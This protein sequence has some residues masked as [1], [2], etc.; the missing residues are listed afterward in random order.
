MKKLS[1][2]KH[3]ILSISALFL[4][5][6]VAAGITFSWIEGGSSFVIKSDDTNHTLKTGKL[7]D[8]NHYDGLLLDPDTN[9][10]LDLLKFDKN[11]GDAQDLIFTQTYSYDGENFYF[12]ADEN[13]HNPRIATTN[14]KGT[15]FINFSF[16]SKAVKDCYL[17]FDNE[18]PL[19]ITATKGGETIDTSAFRVMIKCGNDK[20]IL[21]TAPSEQTSKIYDNV[22]NEHTLTAEPAST[23]NYIN[24]NDTTALS[25][26][27]KDQEK[28][29]E[30]SVWLDAQ[31]APAELLGG[32]A[33]IEMQIKVAVRKFDITF[34]A[35]T[36]TNTG[37]A[38]VSSFTGGDITV[39]GLKQTAKY[40]NPYEAGTSFTAAA[41]PAAN[42]DFKGWY[43]NDS[44]CDLASRVSEATE[45][46]Y[47]VIDNA[48]YYA[49]FVEK[50]KYDISV[51]ARA[52]NT[53]DATLSNGGGTVY[54]NSSD[55]TT[56]SA[57][58]DSEVT[59]CAAPDS[60][61]RFDGWYT[62]DACT[63]NIGDSYRD[64][65]LQVKV[66]DTTTYYA[67]FVKQFTVTL[68]SVTD[69][70]ISGTGGEGHIDADNTGADISKTVDVGTSVSL[71]GSPNT[72]YEYK[73]IYAT[74]TGGTEITAPVIITVNTDVTYY[75][76]FEEL[77][78]YTITLK[79]VTDGE[80]SGTGGDSQIDSDTPGAS[81]Q[82]TVYKN[83]TVILSGTANTG[84][85]FNGI[86]E[87][88]TD[89][90]AI[91]STTVNVT[92]D[93]TYYARF[94]KKPQS[95]TTI[96]FEQR[97]GYSSYNVWAYNSTDNTQHYCGDTWPGNAA[98]Y[99]SST[100]YYKIDF[101]TEDTGKFK[102]IV[103]NDGSSQHPARG[104]EGLE[105]T[106]GGTYFFASG[107]PSTLEEYNP[108]TVTLKAV[109]NGTVSGT[110]G[111]VSIN[112][113]TSDATAS[114]TVQKDK[115][116][117][118]NGTA[119]SGYEFDGIYTAATGGSRVTS[120]VTPTTSTTYYARFTTE[121]TDRTIYLKPN[122]N[123]LQS[124]ARFAVYVWDSSGK[125]W[126]NMESDGNGYY[127]VTIPKK[128]SN[129]IFARMNPSTTDN[130]F[131]SG[132]CWNQTV[133]QTIPT[134]GKNCFIINS[135]DW[136]NANGT[137]TTK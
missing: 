26:Y 132:T 32:H 69:G 94:T 64:A 108:V 123:W 49:K 61:Y 87:S 102:V 14:D 76:R 45:I 5:L 67:K 72:G 40:T 27:T 24:G 84:Y 99:D 9:A 114:L 79:S 21:T 137:W 7:N 78:K 128:Y 54:V 39:D 107:S 23:Y 59:I 122:S 75:A 127:K 119:K 110:G 3:I 44:T 11:T 77:P 121:S 70:E 43:K 55:T 37:V 30:V 25:E 88:A 117:T 10:T 31:N 85:D 100:G 35:V 60:G 112:G 17:S 105:G 80:I 4:I 50:P 16:K 103:S 131:N 101:T 53:S 36:Y 18:N 98:S 15:K 135:G 42:Y 20:K 52:K 106:I 33:E 118:L 134:D 83:T 51:V 57:Y 34:D 74:E 133:D 66:S 6:L 19:T 126:Y 38:T 46:S 97:N 63:T 22:G 28:N 8:N 129:I 81:V 86:Y 68:K 29:I 109:T 13:D 111:N 41:N 104:K 1:E 48:T 125:E 62:D 95:T 65:T 120:P 116:V 93:K 130:N 2:N 89:G 73:G 47:A 115:S 56:Y 58:R 136:D 12:P 91:T 92:A 124:D 113:G 90:S 82:K 96:Y 71:S